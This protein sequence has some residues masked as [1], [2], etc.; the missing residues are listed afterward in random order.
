[1][2]LRMRLTWAAAVTALVFGG[3]SAR[4]A[5]TTFLNNGPSSNRVD[6]VFMGD[7]YTASTINTDYPAHVNAMMSHFFN[8]GQDPYPRYHNF[9]NAHRIDVISNEAGADVPP[10]G[11]F[12]DTAL[13]ASYYFD[14]VTERLLSVNTTKANQKLTTELAGASFSAEMKLVTV[15]DT[16]YGGAGGTYAVY[17]GGNGSATEIALHELGHSFDGLADE[18]GG[19]TGTYPGGEPGEINVTKN[20]TGAKW[21]QWLGYNQPGIGVIGAYEGGRYYDHG[22]YRP[23]N[24]SKMRSLGRPFD[25]VA[26]EKIILDIYKFVDP[27]DGYT[28]NA[29]PLTDASLRV[30]TVDPDVIDVNWYV[31]GTLVPGATDETFNLASFGYGPGTYNVMARAFDPTDWVRINLNQLRQDVSWTLTLTPEPSCVITLWLL[32]LGR[33]RSRSIRPRARATAHDGAIN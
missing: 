13:D 15:G 1:M 19:N 2:M 23:S 31:N 8:E 32:P 14:G 27:L 3:A 10:L 6:I 24:N 30:D 18:Y 11:I 16:R 7:G 25:A 26:R 9:F 33:R 12:R 5:W 22:I 17:A 4:A 20:S 29:S 28:S 21:S